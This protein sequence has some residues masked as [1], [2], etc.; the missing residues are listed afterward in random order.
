MQ[1]F[2]ADGWLTGGLADR[3]AT[4]VPNAGPEIPAALVL[5]LWPAGTSNQI[6]IQLSVRDHPANQLHVR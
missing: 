5:P 2:V 3:H 4:A 6:T 1:F